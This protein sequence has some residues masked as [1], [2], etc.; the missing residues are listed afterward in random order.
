MNN[1]TKKE[2]KNLYTSDERKDLIRGSLFALRTQNGYSQKE[3]A[4]KLGIKIGTYSTYETGRSE[5]TAEIIV[6]LAYLYDVT[7]DE[8]LQ[9]D[10]LLKDTEEL[11][12]YS[13]EFTE[14][15]KKLN[16][17][18]EKGN[19]EAIKTMQTLMKNNT[20]FTNNLIKNAFELNNNTDTEE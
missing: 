2:Y 17:L 4:E 10:N 9:K 18:V 6:R 15:M 13:L 1:E 19:P 5:P 8:I 3:V 20:D 16:E 12:K 11:K 14:T 7:T